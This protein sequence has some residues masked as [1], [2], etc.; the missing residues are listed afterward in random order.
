MGGDEDWI[1]KM[2]AQGEG[3]IVSEVYA[4]RRGLKQGDRVS[5]TFNGIQHAWQVLALYRDYRT[6][7]GVVFIDLERF[8]QVYKDQRIGGANLFVMPGTDPRAV[9]SDLLKRFGVQY[10]LSIAIGKELRENVLKVFDETFSITYVLMFIAL[11]VAALGV[12]TTLSLLI[13]ERRRQLGM[14][15]AV[16]GS[17]SQVR[18]MVMLEALLMGGVGHIVGMGCGLV[19]SYLLIYVVNK[20][21]FG[22]TFLYKMPPWTGLLSFVLISLTAM[23][24][25]IP[26][27]NAASRINLAELLKGQ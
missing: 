23:V 1:M 10:A 25:A 24:A 21:S 11:V 8:Q 14:I 12:A 13:R 18:L 7:G 6:G 5:L 27:A 15:M 9:R 22:W 19:L 3:I 26:P 20:Q 17:P 16:G 4:T 2:L